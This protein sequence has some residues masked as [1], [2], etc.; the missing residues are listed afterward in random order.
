MI[1]TSD[2]AI[3]DSMQEYTLSFSAGDVLESVGV[4][5]GV[6][7]SN[8]SSGDTWVGLDNVRLEVSPGSGQ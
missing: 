3:T 1:A 6:E 7:F 5:V 4:N 8:S 2:V